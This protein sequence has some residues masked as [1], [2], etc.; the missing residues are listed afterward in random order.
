MHLYIYVCMYVYRVGG[1]YLKSL[2]KRQ[3]IKKMKKKKYI[4]KCTAANMKIEVARMEAFP[5]LSRPVIILSLL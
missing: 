4:E 3:Q 1:Q 5:F 2:V